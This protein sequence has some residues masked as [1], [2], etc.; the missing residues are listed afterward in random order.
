MD[1]TN[2]QDFYFGLAKENSKRSTCLR[3]RLGVVIV[4]GD[5]P[6]SMGYS[7]AP[8]G[9]ANCCDIGKCLR[10]EMNIPQ[11]ERYEL[12]RSV[13]AEQNA[14]INAAAN[15]VNISGGDLYSYCEDVKTGE[16]YPR[17]CC[18]MCERVLINAK[19][20]NVYIKTQDGYKHF[21]VS[22]WVRKED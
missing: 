11:G 16:I 19:I 10:E 18:T 8:R 14:V 3:R 2:K 7:G 22:D 15:G 9:R 4:K 6:V 20:E 5:V 13:H 1:R 17:E 12:C 21:K